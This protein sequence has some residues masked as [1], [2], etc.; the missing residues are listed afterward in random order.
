MLSYI[1]RERRSK[2]ELIFFSSILECY[3]IAIQVNKKSNRLSYLPK[4]KQQFI[5]VF[6]FLN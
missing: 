1:A 2:G 3:E 5:D 4:L 6:F